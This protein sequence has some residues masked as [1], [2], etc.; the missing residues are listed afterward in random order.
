VNVSTEV[1]ASLPAN[2][3]VGNAWNSGPSGEIYRK[4][5]LYKDNGALL[6]DVD[7]SRYYSYYWAG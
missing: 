7:G 3:I 1:A 4:F 2:A 6:Y 5:T